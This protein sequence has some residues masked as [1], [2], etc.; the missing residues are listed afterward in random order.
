MQEI[1]ATT[2]SPQ[3]NDPCFCG[4]GQRFRQCC[5]NLA[6]DRKPP[7]GL[8]IIEGAMS[9]EKC[10][11]IA[12]AC[13]SAQK[14]W[15][16]AGRVDSKTGKVEAALDESRVTQQV[17]L[18]RF[19]LE[20]RRMVFDLWHDFVPDATGESIEW[21]EDP[22]LLHYTA[23]GKF[24]AHAD[25]QSFDASRQVWIRGIDRDF[26]MLVYCN[27][28][29]EGGTLFFP[30][31]N[32]RYRPKQGDLIAFPSD[33]RYMHA[34]EPVTSGTRLCI[35]SWAAAVGGPRA[36]D[37]PPPSAIPMAACIDGDALSDPSIGKYN[38]PESLWQ[39][40]LRKLKD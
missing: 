4:S 6:E 21:F 7:H 10:R 40:F 14:E 5:G 15:L 23:G 2:F 29:F 32:F 13:E 8:H 37:E 25:N 39:R 36:F 1:T 27:N 33:Q 9:D 3:R 26:S 38:A 12:A 31:F 18:G 34:A 24:D 20:L 35:V 30:N 16:T 19:Q 28:G 22:G 11:E 17:H